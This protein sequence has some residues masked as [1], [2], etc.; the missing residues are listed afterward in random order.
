MVHDEPGAVFENPPLIA[1]LTALEFFEFRI[2]LGM[3]L[4]PAFVQIP[5][6]M[7]HM[8]FNY[9]FWKTLNERGITSMSKVYCAEILDDLPSSPRTEYLKDIS[10]TASGDGDENENSKIEQTRENESET[11][12]NEQQG[13]QQDKDQLQDE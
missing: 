4:S 13:S 7:Q 11:L 12:I 3:F 6:I 9:V 1:G 10:E 8:R 5:D 2:K